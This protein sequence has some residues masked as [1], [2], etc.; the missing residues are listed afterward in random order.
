[1]E[2]IRKGN[3]TGANYIVSVRKILQEAEE[4]DRQAM[5]RFHNW[6]NGM[7]DPEEDAAYTNA[8]QQCAGK[9]RESR[10]SA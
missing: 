2:N 4:R 1:M 8:V 7:M 5:D 10:K 6:S 3:E 9:L